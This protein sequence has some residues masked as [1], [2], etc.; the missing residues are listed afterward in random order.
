M[1]TTPGYSQ[2]NE[3]RLPAANEG[4]AKMQ[5]KVEVLELHLKPLQLL[6]SFIL[7]L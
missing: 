6:D 2:A 5:M 7:L 4:L 3:R 1:L